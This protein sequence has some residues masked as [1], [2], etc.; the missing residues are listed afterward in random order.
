MV[1]TEHAFP[2]LSAATLC[3]EP[4][5]AVA[6]MCPFWCKTSITLHTSTGS[7]SSSGS[8]LLLPQVSLLCPAKLE[9]LLI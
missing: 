6:K 4:G 1:L 2:H 7:A 8:L 5:Y 9:V 3:K